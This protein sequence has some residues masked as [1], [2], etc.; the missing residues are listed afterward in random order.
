MSKLKAHTLYGYLALLALV[1]LCAGCASTIPEVIRQEPT[2]APEIGAVRADPVNMVGRAVRWGGT[3]AAV[4]NR[5]GETRLELVERTLDY[6]GEPLASDRSGGRFL[7]DVEGFL[8]PMIYTVGRSLTVYGELAAAVVGQVGE[9][10]YTYPLIRAQSHYLWALPVRRDPR[11]DEWDP[12]WAS[13]W[14]PYPYPWWHRHPY[15]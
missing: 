1:M 15:W 12:P 14:Y 11:W 5:K 8:D 7:V 4:D 13:P 2:Q 9:Y 10:P 3:I 6:Q